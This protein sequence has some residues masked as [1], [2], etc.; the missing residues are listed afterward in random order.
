MKN[1][2][3]YFYTGLLTILMSMAILIGCKDGSQIS[4]NGDPNKDKGSYETNTQGD[5]KIYT[6]YEIDSKLSHLHNLTAYGNEHHR[7]VTVKDKEDAIT[8][9][10]YIFT[11]YKEDGIWKCQKVDDMTCKCTITNPL[12]GENGG[13]TITMVN[14]ADNSKL[15]EN[16][17]VIRE[18]GKITITNNANGEYS[19]VLKI[20]D[21]EKD[22]DE[23]ILLELA[24]K[25]IK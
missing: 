23:K 17:K 14:E 16:G 10:W 22:N 21:T 18:S 8:V 13:E 5:G 6:L 19:A 11:V 20:K 9:M 15:A 24:K 7:I 12:Q 4:K 1:K 3:N 2:N 25:Q